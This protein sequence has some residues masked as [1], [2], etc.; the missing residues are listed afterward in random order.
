MGEE[1]YVWV[2]RLTERFSESI[3]NIGFKYKVLKGRCRLEHVR[4]YQR[5]ITFIDEYDLECLPGSVVEY[6]E[7][8]YVSGGMGPDYERITRV[9]AYVNEDGSVKR[10]NF[11]LQREIGGALG[12]N[13]IRRHVPEECL[14]DSPKDGYLRVFCKS[15]MDY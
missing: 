1:N 2:A 12:E 11:V 8:A 13:V 14:D 4:S 3:L 15:I 6:E 9:L 7:R 5:M 10:Y